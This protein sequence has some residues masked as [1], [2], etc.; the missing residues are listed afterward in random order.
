MV[1]V[2]KMEQENVPVGIIIY[3]ACNCEGKIKIIHGT[4]LIKRILGGWQK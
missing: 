4:N 2:C 1:D 3:V